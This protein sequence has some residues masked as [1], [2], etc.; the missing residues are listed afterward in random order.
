MKKL[1]MLSLSIFLA[2]LL[3]ACGAGGETSG[4]GGNPKVSSDSLIIDN[5][6]GTVNNQNT[7]KPN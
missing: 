2:S 4:G 1:T 5:G 3:I 6:R 7:E